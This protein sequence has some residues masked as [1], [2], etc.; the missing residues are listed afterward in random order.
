MVPFVKSPHDRADC[1]LAAVKA[2]PVPWSQTIKDLSLMGSQMT[3]VGNKAALIKEQETLVGH[4][5]ILKKYNCKTLGLSGRRL[6]RLFQFM[7]KK[8]GEEGY[9]DA[10]EV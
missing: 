2:A 3:G 7:I 5:Q 6:E 10:L 8:S 9:E 1:I 4:K